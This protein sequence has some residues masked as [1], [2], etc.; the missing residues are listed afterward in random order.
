MREAA[1]V[2]AGVSPRNLSPARHVVYVALG[3]ACWRTRL[4]LQTAPK[5]GVATATQR[6]RSTAVWSIGN[7]GG[8][9]PHAFHRIASLA[10]F[11]VLPKAFCAARMFPF[12]QRRLEHLDLHKDSERATLQEKV[13]SAIAAEKEAR[14]R[15]AE[16]K[17]AVEAAQLALKRAHRIATAAKARLQ[18]ERENL[19]QLAKNQKRKREIAQLR[20]ACVGAVTV[21]LWSDAAAVGDENGAGKACG[22]G[23][24]H[25]RAMAG[26]EDRRLQTEHGV[27]C[28]L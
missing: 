12:T 13:S 14:Q 7:S 6:Q 9:D 24:R 22:V 23:D 3:D 11:A 28:V 19:G 2:F 5:C 18:R 17:A 1:E 21:D 4:S 20:L 25:L 16:A 10:R 27:R 8:A 15:E 26:L